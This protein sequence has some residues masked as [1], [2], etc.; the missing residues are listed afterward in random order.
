VSEAT[1]GV[2]SEP[3]VLAV[4][5]RDHC[6]FG[7]VCRS[8]KR[9]GV[10]LHALRFACPSV[11]VFSRV[12]ASGVVALLMLFSIVLAVGSAYYVGVVGEYFFTTVG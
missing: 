3:S 2:S 9:R 1:R 5:L 6:P 11:P 8:V 12:S 4:V 7:G 10:A